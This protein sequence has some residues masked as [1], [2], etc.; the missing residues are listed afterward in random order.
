M[1]FRSNFLLYSFFFLLETRLFCGFLLS[2]FHHE[3]F[4]EIT[5]ILPV[6]IIV[7]SISHEIANKQNLNSSKSS[8]FF[9]EFFRVWSFQ[10]AL[11][12][13]EHFSHKTHP[14]PPWETLH[15][16]MYKMKVS[17][18]GYNRIMLE[19]GVKS[20][21]MHQSCRCENWYDDLNI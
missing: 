8:P 16:N 12:E 2:N 13:I 1:I 3:N 17:T 5:K 20:I 6:A 21:K 7:P 14:R 9:H 15:C 10:T 11:G 19:M 18:Q 4:L